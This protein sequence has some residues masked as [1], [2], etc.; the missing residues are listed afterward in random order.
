MGADGLLN[1]LVSLIDCDTL[2]R[3]E[4]SAVTPHKFRLELR[5]DWH[6]AETARSRRRSVRMVGPE[7]KRCG[8]RNAIAGGKYPVGSNWFQ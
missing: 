1:N 3:L 6:D 4:P 7:E 8:G 2:D 5:T